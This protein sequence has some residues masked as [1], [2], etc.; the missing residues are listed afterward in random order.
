MSVHLL[1]RIPWAA[2]VWALPFL[3]ALFLSERY[4]PFMRRRRARKPPVR[5]ARALVA[6]G[7]AG[8]NVQVRHERRGHGD[9]HH[10]AGREQNFKCTTPAIHQR[11]NLAG[12]SATARANGLAVRASDGIAGTL[13]DPP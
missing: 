2:R 6:Q 13:V 12:A 1:T 10:V 8:A 11:V 7:A 9:V 4:A 3:T 5:H